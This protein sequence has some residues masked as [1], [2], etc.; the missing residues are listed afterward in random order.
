MAL[1]RGDVEPLVC[2]DEVDRH[3]A[4]RRIRD[5]EL[6]ERLTVGVDRSQRGGVDIRKVVT[7]HVG[8]PL[9]LGASSP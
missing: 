6:V 7:G 5:A 8:L 2:R 3:R 1:H 4:A 9:S